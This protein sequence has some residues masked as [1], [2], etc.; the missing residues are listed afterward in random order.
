LPVSS[1]YLIRGY[2]SVIDVKGAQRAQ[3]L[4]E[5]RLSKQYLQ[6]RSRSEIPKCKQYREARAGPEIQPFVEPKHEKE[7]NN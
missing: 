6:H 4:A 2:S 3:I 5:R 7:E 1:T